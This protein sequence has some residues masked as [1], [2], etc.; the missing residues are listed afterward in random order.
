MLSL[1]SSQPFELMEVSMMLARPS[2][3]V[4]NTRLWSPQLPL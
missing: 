3:L 1:L 2:R 4:T